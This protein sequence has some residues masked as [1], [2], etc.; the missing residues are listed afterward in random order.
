MHPSKSDFVVKSPP[1]LGLRRSVSNIVRGSAYIGI[2][3]YVG[4]GAHQP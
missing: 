3:A 2:N 4:L 1:S